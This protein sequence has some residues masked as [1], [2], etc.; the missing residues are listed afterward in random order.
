MENRVE[1][2]NNDFMNLQRNDK[3]RPLAHLNTRHGVGGLSPVFPGHVVETYFARE[4]LRCI[5]FYFRYN[6]GLLQKEVSRGTTCPRSYS[7][8]KAGADDRK[9]EPE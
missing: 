8:F 6:L 4:T 2:R 3:K 9:R 1:V 7:L 5:H